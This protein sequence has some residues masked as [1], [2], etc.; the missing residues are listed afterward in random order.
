M[1][2]LHLL[3]LI[4]VLS[5]P[6]LS[7]PLS[8]EEALRLG[9]TQSPRLSA[10]RFAA[11]A[12]AEQVGRAA[13]LPDPKL[14]L[15][16]ENLPVTGEDRLRYDRDFM[17]MRSVGLMQEFP[18]ADKR[19]ARNARASRQHELENA[20]VQ[21]QVSSLRR[22]IASAWLE[23]HYADR[24]REALERR[25]RQFRLQADAVA[26]GLARGRQ[27]AAESFM[28]Q[29][30]LESANIG[31]IEQ[32]RQVE[33][34]RL[35][36]GVWIGAN[37]RRELGPAPDTARL[38]Y[39]R[40][41]LLE[42][43]ERHPALRTSELRESLARAEVA[44]ARSAKKSDWALE[45][46]YAHRRPS[47]DNMVTVMATFELPWQAGRRQDR[48]VASRLAELEQARALREDEK[49]VREAELR[50]WLADF[51]SASRRIERFERVLQPLAR[52]RAAAAVAAFRGA[53]GELAPVLEAER[54]VTET[55][56]ELIQTLAERGRAWANL[57]YLLPSEGER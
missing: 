19:A 35:A 53:R 15:G 37:A 1:K 45:L 46:G 9:A 30:A 48:D 49:R 22:E 3:V 14:R 10:Q 56:I 4:A 8:L 54:S 41:R 5:A 21:A 38:A 51:E 42:Q 57:S 6:A 31:V 18:N 55:E 20:N 33:R 23:V 25:A 2:P 40:R 24:G 28:L 17:T 26:A 11:S 29:Q 16:L 47:F 13:E 52:E 32:E 50:G 7:E 44:L 43:L 39:E 36:L 27:N 12:A 34:A